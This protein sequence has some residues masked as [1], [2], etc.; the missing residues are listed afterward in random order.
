MIRPCVAALV[1]TLLGVLGALPLECHAQ[2]SVP[3]I[4]KPL[5]VEVRVVGVHVTVKDKKD[6]L[7]PNLGVAEFALQEDGEPTAP[8]YFF[9]GGSSKVSLL[10]VLLV[11]TSTSQSHVLV[12]ERRIATKF[13]ES[14]LR[15]GDQ[16]AVVTFDSNAYVLQ[17]PTSDLARLDRTLEH[18][19]PFAP[20]IAPELPHWKE[21][22]GTRAC[23]AVAWVADWQVPSPADRKVVI[24]ISD[25]VDAELNSQLQPAVNAVLRNDVTIYAIRII[26]AGAYQ[27]EDRS[28]VQAGERALRQMA[29]E[30][31]GLFF[32]G[33]NPDRLEAAF[34]QIAA[35]VRGQYSIGFVPRYLTYNARFHRINVAVNHKGTYVRARRGYFSPRP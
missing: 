22:N 18:I 33:N 8:Y 4:D 25:G 31:G 16:A 23:A 2:S 7:V 34:A 29:D 15:P 19:Q 3:T 35:E 9:A 11:D 17:S 28:R 12:K 13:L 27:W 26:D 6:Q 30:T 20:G 21:V 32:T 24:L 14:V 5:R 10:V 1:A